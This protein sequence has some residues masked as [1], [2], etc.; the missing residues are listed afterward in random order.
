MNN[1]SCE[2]GMTQIHRVITQALSAGSTQHPLRAVVFVGDAC[3]E[4]PERLMALA[5]QCGIKRIPLFLFQ[6]GGDAKTRDIFKGLARLSHGAYAPFDAQSAEQLKQ[7]LG[8]VV[9]Y[10][11]GGLKA[12]RQSAA[13]G[14]KLL[15]EQLDTHS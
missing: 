2:A 7:L 13:P 14:D 5:G 6:E 15:L 1:V 12:L 10:A 11:M 3:E 8:A 9:R 4:D